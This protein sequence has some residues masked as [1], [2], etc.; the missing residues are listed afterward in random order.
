MSISLDASL[1]SLGAILDGED[2]CDH[3]REP[4]APVDVT[5]WT[6]LDAF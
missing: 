3:V 1:N 5:T 2:D 6:E 4:Q